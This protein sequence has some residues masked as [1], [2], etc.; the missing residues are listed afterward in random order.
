M[1]ILLREKKSLHLIEEEYKN[2][3]IG[4]NFKNKYWI[5]DENYCLEK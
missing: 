5:D 3:Y 1:D 4:W 2:D